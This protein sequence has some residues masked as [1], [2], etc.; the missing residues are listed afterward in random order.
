MKRKTKLPELLCPAG[1]FECLIAAVEAGADAVYV[2]GRRFGARAYAKNFDLDELSRAVVYCSLRGVRLYVTMNTLIE[3]RE[4]EDAV[5]YAAELYKIGVSAVIITDTGLIR[6]VRRRVPELELH[7]STQ[8][9]VH[10]SIGVNEAVRLGCK[11]V[12][13]ARELSLDNIK[14]VV[15]NSEA[16]IEV[17]LHGALCV[18]HS[19][20]C[21]MSSMVGG[22]SGNR[23]ECAQP[24]RLPYLTDKGQGYP[25]S[26]KDLALAEHIPELIESGVASLKIEGRMKAPSYVYTVTSVYRRLLDERRRASREEMAVLQRAFS[27]QGFTDGYFVGKTQQPMTGIRTKEDKEQ[28]KE[29]SEVTVASSQYPVRATVEIKRNQPARITLTDGVRCVTVTGDEPR[30]A[31]NHPLSEEEVR[32][33]VTKTGG[34]MLSLKAEDVFV[35]LDEGLNLSP[36]SQNRL[37]REAIDAFCNFE[38]ALDDTGYSYTAAKLPTKELVS[39]EFYRAEELV[40]AYS[41]SP[42]LFSGIDRMFV[43]L[44]S[45]AEAIGLAKGVMLPSVITDSELCGVREQLMRAFVSGAKYALVGNIGHI[46]LAREAGLVPIGGFRLNIYNRAARESMLRV[47]IEEAVLSPELT[48]PKARDTG[49]GVIVL[50]RIPLMITE[51]CFIKENFGCSRCGD[52]ALTDRMGERFP[53]MRE[54]DHRNIILNSQITYMGDK[55]DELKSYGIKHKHLLFSCESA[56]E[57][58]RELDSYLYAKPLGTRVRRVG[59]RQIQ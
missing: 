17:F 33:R 39:A 15:D 46:A 13:A 25:L 18:C 30:D 56:E 49:G 1:D 8:M 40:R 7:A 42:E 6:E 51:R 37:R 22:R 43:P 41:S 36:S 31:I 9:S 45:R 27:R 29:L 54:P 44:D 3:D 4:M 16:E 23:G 34:T 2:G 59:K 14:R 57:I 5:N 11:R 58:I 10:N 26:L 12:V 24:C 48:L 38:R 28:T 52:A 21:L 53:M 35:E 50:G 55:A 32:A 19:G 47:G 20:Q